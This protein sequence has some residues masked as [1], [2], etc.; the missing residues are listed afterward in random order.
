LG[1]AIE[2]AFG[3]GKIG[4][5]HIRLSVLLDN[6]V[7]ILLQTFL[8]VSEVWMNVI[9]M[10]LASTLLGVMTVCATL[11]SPQATICYNPDPLFQK[12]SHN[13]KFDW[14]RRRISTLWPQ[15]VKAGRTLEAQKPFK[16]TEKSV[17][18]LV[19]CLVVTV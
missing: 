1:G 15:W 6:V 16:H 13:S 19:P 9:Q 12:L 10:Q 8:S 11:G 3:T 17:R 4:E 14:L 5:E 2:Q 7:T 18:Q